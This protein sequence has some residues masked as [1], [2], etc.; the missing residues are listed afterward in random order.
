MPKNV[1]IS[2]GGVDYVVPQMNIGQI[3]DLSEISS[4]A[5][6]P[7]FKRGRMI[8]EVILRRAV[9]AIPSVRDLECTAEELRAATDTVLEMSGMA[10]VASPGEAQ[11]TE[12]ASP[13]AST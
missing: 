5:S 6:L 13:I 1:T 7:N 2:L 10:K 4:D 3:E 11:A 8:S 9:P 12:E